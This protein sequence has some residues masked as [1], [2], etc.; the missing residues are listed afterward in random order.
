MPERCCTQEN[1][2]GLVIFF[3]ERQLAERD[4]KGKGH[5]KEHRQLEVGFL[6][7]TKF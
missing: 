6:L 2:R 7:F 4:L 1:V 3:F 5:E